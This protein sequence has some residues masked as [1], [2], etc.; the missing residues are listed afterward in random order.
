MIAPMRRFAPVLCAATLAAC[1]ASPAPSSPQ[2]PPPAMVQAA[3]SASTRPVTIDPRNTGALPRN[4]AAL[5]S[6]DPDR[7]SKA[8]AELARALPP[9]RVDLVEHVLALPA[10]SIAGGQ[11]AT[12]LGI[13]PSR[14]VVMALAPLDAHGQSILKAAS[15]LLSPT[16]RHIPGAQRTLEKALNAGRTPP[17]H[18]R[19]TVPAVDQ[20]K[21]L[22]RL[23]AL[24]ESRLYTAV[25]APEDFDSIYARRERVV[26]LSRGPGVI[27]VDIFA[28]AGAVPRKKTIAE[29]A[30][31]A[32]ASLKSGPG[33]EP[34]AVGAS[35]LR[36]SYS[37]P[38][39]ADVAFVESVSRAHD[40]LGWGRDFELDNRMSRGL[41]D[42]GR[43]L[44]VARSGPVEFYEN[45]D[46]SVDI[47]GGAPGLVV[48]SI[49]GAA[50]PPPKCLPSISVDFSGALQRFDISTTCMMSL[51][52]PGDNNQDLAHSQFFDMLRASD[53]MMAPIALPGML[54][55][56][57]RVPLRWNAGTGPHA[58]LR[59]ERFGWANPS[60][61][62][63][64]VFWGIV[65]AGTKPAAI[66]CAV[67]ES[68]KEC[69][70]KRK[71]KPEG[72]S[73]LGDAFA[74]VVKL[75]DRVV[76]LT[77]RDRAALEAMNPSLTASPVPALRGAVSPGSVA[78][79]LA[80]LGVQGAPP[81]YSAD[82]VFTLKHVTF[83]LKPS[84]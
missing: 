50:T 20:D 82:A 4:P 5:A 1:G 37:P 48:Q 42:A 52:A 83:T 32:L 49:F 84:P 41:Y 21:L 10:G 6:L 30:L 73:D 71:I 55:G 16:Q 45:V 60:F 19:V 9:E 2:M 18:I 79:M 23:H 53:W 61:G 39:A 64:D 58:M 59:F 38:R 34:L 11:L 62:A 35:V 27:V 66:A 63:P 12:S 56:A 72:F 57:T 3:P 8:V 47:Q 24:I 25:P 74:R 81:R 76:V 51:F 29:V 28:F 36:L 31:A 43:Y 22:G 77:S 68:D 13:D 78:R 40:L 44:R 54:A 15:K 33:A 69:K 46:V 26:A 7:F 70:G 14:P 17:T 80:G 65:P 67:A 75:A